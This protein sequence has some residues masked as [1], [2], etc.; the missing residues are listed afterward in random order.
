M[1]NIIVIHCKLFALKTKIIINLK[2]LYSVI[3]YRKEPKQAQAHTSK[4][5]TLLI[6][7]VK[8]DFNIELNCELFGSLGLRNSLS[9]QYK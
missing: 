9:S 3:L 8:S 1:F 2:N 5:N 6:E 7:D 4:T